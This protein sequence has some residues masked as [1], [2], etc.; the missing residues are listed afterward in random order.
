MVYWSFL[1]LIVTPAATR[2]AQLVCKVPFLEIANT[3]ERIT[4]LTR[5]TLT[6][7]PADYA[8]ARYISQVLTL[9]EQ[10]EHRALSL[11][12]GIYVIARSRNT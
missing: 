7:S 1:P 2:Q 9:V 4:D 12:N 5:R 10:V 11:V 3:S 8:R 6:R